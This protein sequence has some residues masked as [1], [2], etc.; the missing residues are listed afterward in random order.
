L[1]LKGI[2]REKNLSFIGFGLSED[3]GYKNKKEE[4]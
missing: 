1:G 2:E 3:E 4:G